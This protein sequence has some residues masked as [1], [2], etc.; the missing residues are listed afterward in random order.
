MICRV[1]PHVTQQFNFQILQRLMEIKVYKSKSDHIYVKYEVLSTVALYISICYIY[2][3][4]LSVTYLFIV[5]CTSEAAHR[6]IVALYSK[7]NFICF[8][9]RNKASEEWARKLSVSRQIIKPQGQ[10]AGFILD[11]ISVCQWLF[12]C[13]QMKTDRDLQ[14]TATFRSCSSLDGLS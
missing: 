1:Q 6:S 13:T 11:T 7:S 8:M 10:Q 12:I 4:F 2:F 3:F 5:V 9:P 14:L